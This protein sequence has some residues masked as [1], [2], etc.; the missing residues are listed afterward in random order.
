MQIKVEISNLV[1]ICSKIDQETPLIYEGEQVIEFLKKIDEFFW[2]VED[3]LTEV[4]NFMITILEFVQENKLQET[5]SMIVPLKN[6]IRLIREVCP[7][8]EDATL[9]TTP[10]DGRT[11]PGGAQDQRGKTS[12]D[13]RATSR[14]SIERQRAELL[15]IQQENKILSKIKEE[16]KRQ[17]ED[18]THL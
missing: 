1:E 10:V 6:I 12:G 3:D 14:G 5:R 8:N 16:K 11:T 13:Y 7:A 15:R 17:R 2:Q 4:K 9:G 18:K